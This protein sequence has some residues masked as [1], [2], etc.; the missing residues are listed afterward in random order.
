MIRRST[1]VAALA[2]IF[3]LGNAHAL[4]LSVDEFDS[5]DVFIFDTVKAA[6]PDATYSDSIR[7]ITHSWTVG[8]VNNNV[9][10]QSGVIMGGNTTPPGSLSMFNGVGQNS[11]VTLEWSLAAGFVPSTGP[12]S[13]FFNVV[14][15]DAVPVTISYALN[16][17]GFTNVATFSQVVPPNVPFAV[18]LTAAQQA[19]L[20]GGG[21]LELHF[22]GDAGWDF[23]IDSFGFQ[24]SE[25]ASL[26]LAGLALLG[27]GAATRRRKA[28]LA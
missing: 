2:T 15:S 26:A 19:A 25:P 13:F 4:F 16:G 1:T 14:G 10:N 27:A 11:D 21:T 5:P 28:K 18:P 7:T 20:T 6:A 9:G 17:G 3:A 8:A 12:V 22:S 24:V 23:A